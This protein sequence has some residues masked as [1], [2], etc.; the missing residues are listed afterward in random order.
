MPRSMDAPRP[1]LHADARHPAD[2]HDLIRVHGTRVNNLKDISVDVPKRRVTGF[3]GVSGTGK[4]STIFGNMAAESQ[5]LNNESYSAFG[6]SFMPSLGR[7]DV[8]SLSGLS[9]A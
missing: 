7:P 2:S 3:T 1:Q 4:N 6:E 9:A 8:D 5:R